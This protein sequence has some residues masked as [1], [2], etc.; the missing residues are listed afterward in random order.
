MS[1]NSR[2]V[3]ST[4]TGRIKP[5]ADTA[6]KNSGDGI[7]RI[8]RET[9]GRKGKGVSLVAG[10]DLDEK[11]LKDLAKELKQKCGVGG[12]VKNGIIEVQ[13]DNRNKLKELLDKK[14]FTVKIAG[15]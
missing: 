12:C 13:T 5:K 11:G 8:T 15:G 6:P 10:V 2:L 1:K 9:K 7:V 4:E 3:Y 14:G